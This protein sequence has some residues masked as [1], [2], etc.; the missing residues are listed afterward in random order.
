MW[1]ACII[2]DNGE[3]IERNN[4]TVES[5]MELHDKLCLVPGTVFIFQGKTKVTVVNDKGAKTDDR[6]FFSGVSTSGLKVETSNTNSDPRPKQD[7]SLVVCRLCVELVFYQARQ[8]PTT[9]DK[10]RHSTLDTS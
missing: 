9:N 5:F 7:Q 10:S 1:S 2:R 3:F 6:G 8:R 4:S